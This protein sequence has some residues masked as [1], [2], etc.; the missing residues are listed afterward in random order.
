MVLN[1]E[2]FSCY[3][4]CKSYDIDG[5]ILACNDLSY[6][7]QS[8]TYVLQGEIDCGAWTFV[9][10]IS[11]YCKHKKI[12]FPESK[13]YVNHELQE[14]K[15]GLLA[16][17]IHQKPTKKSHFITLYHAIERAV[18]KYHFNMTAN[19]LISAFGIPSEYRNRK[20]YTL[21]KYYWVYIA[22]EG[23][24]KGYRIFTTTWIGHYGFEDLILKKIANA[25]LKFDCIFIIPS[26]VNN[27]F[28]F[29]AVTVPMPLLFSNETIRK[30][31]LE[32]TFK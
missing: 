11:K 23:L 2:N 12:F 18:K 8:G 29:P 5:Y 31:Y 32:D 10:A 9:S 15:A 27:K 17:Y 1:I 16:C 7:F 19:E 20:L 24:I 6:Q 4:I 3:C 26:S 13:I 30:I 22:M 14:E 21:G 25:L 28:S